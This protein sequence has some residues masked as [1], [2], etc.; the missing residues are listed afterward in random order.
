MEEVKLT[1]DGKAV[2]GKKGQ[3]ILEIALENGIDIPYLCYH[4]RLSKSGAC[5]ICLVRINGKM[6]KPSCC[7]ERGG[8]R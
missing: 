5:R 6:L 4:P 7:E 1:I 3:T 2:T 8:G